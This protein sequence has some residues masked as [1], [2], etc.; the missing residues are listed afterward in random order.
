MVVRLTELCNEGASSFSLSCISFI[1][2]LF[3]TSLFS[4]DD[5]EEPG[6]VSVVIHNTIYSKNDI[7]F[8]VD[9]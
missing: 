7:R 6:S 4:T 5:P 3:S 8:F 2:F 9:E 1:A